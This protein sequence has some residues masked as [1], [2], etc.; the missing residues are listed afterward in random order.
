MMAYCPHC[1]IIQPA[2]ECPPWRFAGTGEPTTW[3]DPDDP[4][5]A[6]TMVAAMPAAIQKDVTR[7]AS[8][9]KVRWKAMRVE[10]TTQYARN[11]RLQQEQRINALRKE[12]AELESK[13][14]WR[15]GRDNDK[16]EECVLDLSEFDLY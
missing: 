8:M 14:R 10:D 3:M 4:N 5:H 9:C 12:D 16:D 7:L 1:T 11:K 2:E 6:R 15:A 13:R